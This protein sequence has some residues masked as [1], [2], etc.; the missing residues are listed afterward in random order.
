MYAIFCVVFLHFFC[1]SHVSACNYVLFC[2]CYYY[3]SSI[4]PEDK[5]HSKDNLQSPTAKW[6]LLIPAN[7]SK[8]GH[9]QSSC[10]NTSFCLP[11]LDIWLFWKELIKW[12]EVVWYWGFSKKYL[13]PWN[14][15][16][17]WNGTSKHA[18]MPVCCPHIEIETTVV[19]MYQVDSC[20]W[21][22][23]LTCLLTPLNEQTLS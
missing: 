1:M 2:N 7:S 3:S 8:A 19:E 15:V 14:P 20:A 4:K 10:E 22:I 13:I 21:S 18:L 6:K 9:V 11:P 17:M 5:K 16:D 12:L 23:V